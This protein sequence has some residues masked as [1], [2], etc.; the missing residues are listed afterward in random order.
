MRSRTIGLGWAVV[1]IGCSSSDPKFDP[2]L[3]MDAAGPAFIAA[4]CPGQVT[5]RRTTVGNGDTSKVLVRHDCIDARHGLGLS[6]NMTVTYEE[7]TKRIVELQ[8]A[9]GGGPGIDV[10]TPFARLYTSLVEPYLQPSRREAIR[11]FAMGNEGDADMTDPVD[12]ALKF[13]RLSNRQDIAWRSLAVTQ[14]LEPA[15]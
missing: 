6:L 2:L 4:N 5:S 13:R 12:P 10:D 7:A 8:V 3:P 15:P 9:A 1:A 14:R 11:T